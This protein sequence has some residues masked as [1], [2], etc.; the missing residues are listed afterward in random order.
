M[1]GDLGHQLLAELGCGLELGGVRRAADDLARLRF[2]RDQLALELGDLL[3]RSRVWASRLW[4]RARASAA[5]VVSS[6]RRVSAAL[7]AVSA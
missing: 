1:L 6:L 2:E 4:R 7:S 5:A 3:R